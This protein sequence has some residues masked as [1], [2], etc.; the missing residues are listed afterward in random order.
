MVSEVGHRRAGST[1]ARG[2]VWRV[3]F[4]Y[5]VVLGGLCELLLGSISKVRVCEV[6]SRAVLGGRIPS[7][8]DGTG[9]TALEGEV[10]RQTGRT[11]RETASSKAP[12]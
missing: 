1:Q 10:D 8:R 3:F 7:R 12:R 6:V 2:G 9:C 11:H 4:P 5:K